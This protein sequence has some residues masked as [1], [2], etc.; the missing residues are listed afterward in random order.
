MA[1]KRKKK[2]NN[3]YIPKYGLGGFFASLFGG[4]KRKARA[5]AGEAEEGLTGF[6]TEGLPDYMQTYLAVNPSAT[7]IEAK[8]KGIDEF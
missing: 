3:I 6:K 4:R 5:I 1:K 7:A 2:K 8:E